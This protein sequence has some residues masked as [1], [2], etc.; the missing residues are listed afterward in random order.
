MK[1]GKNVKVLSKSDK[2]KFID[3]KNDI[4]NRIATLIS[5]LPIISE[6]GYSTVEDIIDNLPNE[7]FY[8]AT[9]SDIKILKLLVKEKIIDTYKI[10]L[11][12]S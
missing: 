6:L 10:N 2:K 11:Q 12:L 9:K 8:G 7:L 1:K 4:I 5:R 3:T